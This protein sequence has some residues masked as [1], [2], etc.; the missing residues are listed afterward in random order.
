MPYAYLLV[1]I[2]N[3]GEL[4]LLFYR[5]HSTTRYY[6]DD[7]DIILLCILYTTSTVVCNKKTISL[8]RCYIHIHVMYTLLQTHT[9]MHNHAYLPPFSLYSSQSNSSSSTS[10]CPPSPS[11]FSP[12][13]LPPP[14]LVSL[15]V[16]LL[17]H[18]FRQISKHFFIRVQ[19]S[20]NI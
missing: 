9:V 19:A 1:P 8:Y 15:F 13:F 6:K 2:V 18:S 11:Q 7:N 14:P 4:L 16:S 10:S 12:P 17:P 3:E 20:L 5:V